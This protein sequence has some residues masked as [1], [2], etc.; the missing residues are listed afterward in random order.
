MRVIKCSIVQTR[1]TVCKT[2]RDSNKRDPHANLWTYGRTVVSR[3]TDRCTFELRAT[4]TGK[5][6]DNTKTTRQPAA[7]CQKPVRNGTRTNIFFFFCCRCIH[8]LSPS[9]AIDI[10]A[11]PLMVPANSENRARAYL[12]HF[13]RT[14]SMSRAYFYIFFF[15]RPI[16][17]AAV[18]QVRHHLSRAFHFVLTVDSFAALFFSSYI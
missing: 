6:S 11:S 8:T 10:I 3:L 13:R 16:Q 1:Y 14:E 12:T 7:K 17:R 4:D 18:I 5:I 2:Y 9:R 15:P